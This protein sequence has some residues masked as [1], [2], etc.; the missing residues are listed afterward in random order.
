MK[1]I[2]RKKGNRIFSCFLA[3]TMALMLLP[4][5]ALANDTAADASGDAIESEDTN[6]KGLLGTEAG[7][8]AWIGDTGYTS[9]EDAVNAATSG[10]TITLGSGT[11]TLYNKGADVL[12]KDLTFVGAGS[13]QTTWL[14]GPKVANPAKYGTE[15]NSDYSF[16]ARATEYKETVTFKNMT[17]QSGS[18]DYLGFAGTDNTVVEN[19]VIEGKTFYWGY[20]SAT[21][22]NTTF[23][24]PNG[25]YAIWT[26]CSPVMTFDGCTF[27][28]S[29][30]AVNVYT[31]Y[32]SKLYNIT[33]NVND[34]TVN[35]S[36]GVKKPVFKINDKLM[37][38][39]GHTFTI[40]FSGKNTING[41]VK[42]STATCSRWFGFDEDSENT[43][44]TTV[45]IDGTTV[46][47]NAKMLSHEVDTSN[48]KYT[49]GYKDNAYDITYGGWTQDE[50]GA[51]KR[52]VKKTCQYCGYEV[53]TEEVKYAVN[54]D[55]NGGNGDTVKEECDH[56][57]DHIVG[58]NIYS[59]D[60]Y[61]FT[62]WNTKADGSGT[63][64][65]PEEVIKVEEP[66]TLYAQ[67]KEEKTE[68]ETEPE[69]DPETYTVK[70][71]ANGGS[72]SMEDASCESGSEISLSAN[73]FTREGYSF[74]GWNTAADGSGVSYAVGDAMKLTE[75]VTLY[76]QWKE[77]AAEKK[78]SA[79]PTASTKGIATKTAAKTASPKTGD[80][81]MLSWTILLIL[82]IA[83]SAGLVF[84]KRR[85]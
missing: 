1:K 9:L 25:D 44:S 59:K 15:Y 60:G 23:N 29:G 2:F 17:L 73:T 35:A 33:I 51:I 8:V 13:G 84:T 76:A 40:H 57:S 65:T 62:S 19:C 68:P 83:V 78:V 85:R 7:Y 21:F 16:D 49:E 18:V 64:Y 4:S 79:T 37:T 27:N 69:T 41:E 70:Y 10:A 75:N 42:R 43:G 26:Y 20:T 50:N 45:T 72:G 54:Y 14:V 80:S 77:N 36:N 39:G 47:Q 52:S 46:Y 63:S 56:G 32:A 82:A 6:A 34:C 5:M 3:A 12:N 71:D 58:T 66:V 74:T 28:S 38:A 61:E 48:D 81:N 31:D 53:D 55:P 22:K 24:A 67:W 30:K 11:Y